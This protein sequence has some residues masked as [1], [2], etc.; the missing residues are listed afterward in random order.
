VQHK[1][2]QSPVLPH[3]LNISYPCDCTVPA[4]W[5]QLLWTL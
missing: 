2:M 4:Q 5:L 1:L 3:L